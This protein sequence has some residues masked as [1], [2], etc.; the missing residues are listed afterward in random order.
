[1]E[2]ISHRYSY[3]RDSRKSV[4]VVQGGDDAFTPSLPVRPGRWRSQS[5]NRP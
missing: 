4:R 3:P 1:M 5:S 2:T